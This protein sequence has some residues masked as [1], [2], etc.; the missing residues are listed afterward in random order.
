MDFA[1]FIAALYPADLFFLYVAITCLIQ[2]LFL[3]FLRPPPFF[4]CLGIGCA[5]TFES[6]AKISSRLE[7]YKAGSALA[8]AD[9]PPDQKNE[10]EDR[11]WQ[12]PQVCVLAE[13]D[14]DE[15]AP[16]WPFNS[17]VRV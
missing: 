1:R 6:K 2:A 3:R 12:R 9:E 5:G 14:F 16:H 13:E 10:G 11:F 7:D 15:V 8:F 4:A 17:C